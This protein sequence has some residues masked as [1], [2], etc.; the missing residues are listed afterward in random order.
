[1]SRLHRQTGMTLLELMIV[2]GIAGVLSA[3]AVPSF[4][5]MIKSNTVGT[6]RDTLASDIKMARNEAVNTQSPVTICAS[7]DQAACGGTWSDGWI[8]FVD[9][10]ASG[11]RNPATERLVNT[12][13]GNDNIAIG[14]GA[15]TLSVTFSA[16]GLNTGNAATFGICDVDS[17]EGIDG[18]SILLTATG[19]LTYSK[20]ASD[21]S[22]PSP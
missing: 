17:A 13:E 6:Y 8:V 10:D 12:N 15:G 14:N 4:Q 19:S 20:L 22:C 16:L 11:A 7:N 1:M 9:D 21:A 5:N 3:I 2:I 18:R